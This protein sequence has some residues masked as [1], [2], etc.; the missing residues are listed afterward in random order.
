MGN[1]LVT[2]L[3]KHEG[4]K[5]KP[6]RCSAGKLTIGYGR[7]LDDKYFSKIELKFIFGKT[8]I[9]KD[10]VLSILKEGGITKEQAEFL[11]AEDISQCIL[12]LKNKL[13][14]FDS[15]DS[16]RQ[17][18]M[19]DMCFNLG[20]RGLLKFKNTLGLIKNKKYIEASKEMLRSDWANQVGYR[21][22]ELSGMM[23]T[24]KYKD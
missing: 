10:K 6:Y 7:N 22:I 11:L 19:M 17:D 16:V 4:L 9:A 14:W 3:K 23:K 21:A 1:N 20:I 18:I 13:N 2:M 15:I 8:E 5:L 12:D 24:G